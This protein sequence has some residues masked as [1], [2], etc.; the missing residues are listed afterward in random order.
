M[1]RDI[2]TNRFGDLHI[3]D[4]DVFIFREGLPAFEMHKEW[5]LIGNDESPIKWL[6]SLHD[7]AIA[8]PV[9]PPDVIMNGYNAKIS[10]QELESIE[11]ET[12]DDLALFLIVSI[13]PSPR[14]MTVNL[15]APVVINKKKRMGR[16]IIVENEEYAVRQ[17]LWSEEAEKTQTERRTDDSVVHSSS[18]DK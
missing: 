11:M 9:I 5:I 3:D 8:L 18:G 6:Q 13:P 12:L 16:Q 14:D 10:K 2:S 1:A 4:A 15:R 17:R 7:G